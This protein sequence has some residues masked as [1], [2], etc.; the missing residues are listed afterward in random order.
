MA[1]R[2]L[3]AIKWNPNHGKGA[4]RHRRPTQRFRVER[5][6][7]PLLRE[8][9]LNTNWYFLR[10]EPGDDCVDYSDEPYRINED[11]EQV[12]LPHTPRIEAYDVRYPWQGVCWYSHLLVCDPSLLGKRVSIQFGAAMHI[13]DVWIDKTHRTRHLG[14][15]LPFSVDISKEAALGH[16]LRI[17]VR[18]DN[19]DTDLCPPGKETEE[20]DFIY[21][22]GLYR[23][24]KLIV[25][26]PVHVTDP[27]AADVVAGGG[28]FVTYE[29]VSAAQATILIKTHVVNDSLELA[30]RCQVRGVLV[31]SSGATVAEDTA[32]C[33]MISSG[34]SH[35]F[36][37]KIVVSDPNLWSPDNPYLYDL[38]TTVLHDGQPTDSISTRIGI[39]TF[40]LDRRLRINGTECRIR[41][42]NRHQEYPHLGYALSPN[43]ARRDAQLIKDGGFNF[44]RLAHYPQ[45]P[46]FLDACDELGLLVQAPIPGWQIFRYNPSFVSTSYRNIRELVRRDRNHPCV[47]F[48]EPNLNETYG[49]HTDWCRAAYEIAHEE[50]PGDQCFT[51]GDDFSSDWSGW[52][53][54]WFWREYGDFGF[55]GN[56]STSR[57]TR[58]EGEQALLQQAWNF[59]YCLNE[60]SGFQKDPSKDHCGCAAWVMFDYNRGYYH[61]PCTCG[62]MDIFR[63]PKYVYRFYQSQRNPRLIRADVAS[64]P[65][66]FI[67]SDWTMRSGTTKVIVYSNCDEIELIL[68]GKT[69]GRRRP[70]SG[71]DT[72]YSPLESDLHRTMGSGYY[73]D[74]GGTPFDGGNARHL[75]HPPFTFFDVPYAPGTLTA[76]A[77]LDGK[78]VEHVV[79]TPGKP[80]FLKIEFDTQGYPLTADGAD[81]I[82][83]RIYILDQYGTIVPCNEITISVTVDGP[84]RLVN[85]NC[86]HLEAG[87]AT[88]LLQATNEPGA[89]RVR[90]V[91][92]GLKADSATLTS[93][94]QQ[95]PYVLQDKEYS[96][97]YRP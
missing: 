22:G 19:R 51:F 21:P 12:A 48:W 15:Y 65:M 44:V 24:V 87:I 36:R 17:T 39:R 80:C 67:A 38:Q 52:D 57:H 82:F 79:R 9:W 62:L 7:K 64:G 84:A 28:V 34:E 4:G 68:N 86:P 59:Q 93:V 43:A 42:V 41:G 30:R 13:A 76:V 3:S 53:V 29:N 81:V 11:W 69:V 71:P 14:G 27:I 47:V 58:R 33:V 5:T 70:D 35:S 32:E 25:T 85:S 60:L 40:S 1:G 66:V 75:D 90:A 72:K 46:A 20:L 73:D 54:V 26:D 61:K 91:A 92:Q 50:Y 2:S 83:V 37:Q 49:E 88:A 18:L 45:D 78:A 31:D 6:C 23:G 16:P 89:I 63:L 10:C 94:P 96:P 77:Y 95:E 74:S 97:S 55:G 56:E 8:S